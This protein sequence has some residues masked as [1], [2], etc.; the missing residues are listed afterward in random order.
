MWTNAKL[1]FGKWVRSPLCRA[2]ASSGSTPHMTCCALIVQC[3]RIVR[4]FYSNGFRQI[5]QVK[6]NCGINLDALTVGQ[7]VGVKIDQFSMLH[8]VIDGEDRGA[9][10]RD[11]PSICY[12][13]VDLYG[14][15]EQVTLVSLDRDVAADFPIPSTEDREKADKE[16]GT[17]AFL[18]IRRW[19]Y[20]DTSIVF[21]CDRLMKAFVVLNQLLHYQG[22]EA[23]T[24]HWCICHGI[25]SLCST[26]RNRR[27]TQIKNGLSVKWWHCFCFFGGCFLLYFDFLFSVKFRSKGKTDSK[28]ER[29]KSNRSAKLWNFERVFEIQGDAW[30]TR[31]GAPVSLY[32]RRHLPLGLSHTCGLSLKLITKW[33]WSFCWWKEVLLPPVAIS[34]SF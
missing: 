11:L 16:D 15:C 29:S 24:I 23:V 7:T 28:T 33:H 10:F 22:P 9:V 31:W 18:N 30:L 4:L 5:F 17:D 20:S 32:M 26:R 12:A 27:L 8:L 21:I 19:N 3:T 2:V 6:E 14:Q 25:V 13:V 34:V 1:K